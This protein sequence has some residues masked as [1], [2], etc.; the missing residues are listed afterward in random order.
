VMEKA[1]TVVP[2][3]T[4]DLSPTR[5]G[6]RIRRSCL[7]SCFLAPEWISMAQYAGCQPDAL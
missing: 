4:T 1:Q 6:R 2:R 7:R 3:S 5:L